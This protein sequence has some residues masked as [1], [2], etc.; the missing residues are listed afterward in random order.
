MIKSIN[1][2]RDIMEI[3]NFVENLTIK[4]DKLI[5]DNSTYII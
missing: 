1:G 4:V 3:H 2:K 5:A